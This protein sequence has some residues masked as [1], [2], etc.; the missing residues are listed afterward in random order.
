MLELFGSAH[1]A[2]KLPRTMAEVR[3]DR[4]LPKMYKRKRGGSLP[5]K[6]LFALPSKLAHSNHVETESTCENLG[7]VHKMAVSSRPR[8]KAAKLIGMYTWSMHSPFFENMTFLC[9]KFDL[10]CLSIENLFSA[11]EE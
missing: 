3:R 11:E 10:R 6:R 5:R 9:L 8:L 1:T 7:V 4:G 2:S